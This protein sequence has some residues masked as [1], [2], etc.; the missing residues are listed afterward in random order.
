MSY[1]TPLD[2]TTRF[3]ATELAQVCE[4]DHQPFLVT[5]EL[6]RLAAEDGDLSGEDAD[7]QA[8]VAAAIARAE[9]GIARAGRVMDSKLACIEALPLSAEVIGANALGGRAEDIARYL[10]HDDEK[11]E[12]IEIAYKDALAWLNDLVAGRACLLDPAAPA[13]AGAGRVRHGQADSALAW[14]GY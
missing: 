1:T 10:L 3:G 9:A 14:S 7:T 4:R 12:H 5:P 2:M 11:P 8:A 13:A 6:F